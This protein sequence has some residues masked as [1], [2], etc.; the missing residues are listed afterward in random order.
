MASTVAGVGRV[1]VRNLYYPG[2][3]ARDAGMAVGDFG[4]PLPPKVPAYDPAV[5]AVDI[6][7]CTTVAIMG[8]G[9]VEPPI[10]LMQQVYEL[11]DDNREVNFLNFVTK[12][13]FVPV[14]IRATVVPYINRSK[15][16]AIT[17]STQ[18]VTDWLSPEGFGQVP[19]GATD[20]TWASDDRVRLYEAVDFLNR[21]A[22][23]WYVEDVELKIASD[24]IGAF[25]AVDL[26]LPGVFPI[27]VLGTITLS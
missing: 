11:L 7:R 2:T 24:P 12:P 16:D 17:S 14:D 13:S 8:E 4:K 1:S 27:P 19:G 20:K 6:P 3:N 21:G 10:D 9:G 18:M 5:E 15:A 23:T 22:A 25:D 26:M